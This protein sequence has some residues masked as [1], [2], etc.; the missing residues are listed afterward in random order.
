MHRGPTLCDACLTGVR[1]FA[2]EI[3]GH[4]S[5]ATS[6]RYLCEVEWSGGTSGEITLAGL[7]DMV[8]EN[9]VRDGLWTIDDWY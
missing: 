2:G 3:V 7:Q 5:D 9:G 4:V 8:D 1:V 6:R